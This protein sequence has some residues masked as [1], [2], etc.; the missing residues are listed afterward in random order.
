MSSYQNAGWLSRLISLAKPDTPASPFVA[1][2]NVVNDNA[3]RSS[4][5]AA[6]IGRVISVSPAP[7]AGEFAGW[8]L[9]ADDPLRTPLVQLHGLRAFAAG[10][11]AII[12]HIQT[13]TA[14]LIADRTAAAFSSEDQDPD[15]NLSVFTLSTAGGDLPGTPMI[16]PPDIGVTAGWTAIVPWPRV[17]FA[18]EWIGGESLY[19]WAFAANVAVS[20][21]AQIQAVRR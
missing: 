18:L 5:E 19:I 6:P 7:A 1:N 9:R 17:P 13:P 20:L 4:R 11:A 21:D 10:P 16:L 3:F 12:A 14:A 15:V 2:V 8:E